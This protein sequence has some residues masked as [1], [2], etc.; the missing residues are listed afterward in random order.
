MLQAKAN[1]L[2][3]YPRQREPHDR[4]TARLGLR[5]SVEARHFTSGRLKIRC[6]ASIGNLYWQSTEKSVEE[7]RPRLP[8]LTPPPPP[9][10]LQDDFGDLSRRWPPADLFPPGKQLFKFYRG[11]KTLK[12]SYRNRLFCFQHLSFSNVS[13]LQF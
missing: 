12:V 10:S 5:F 11:V 7:D 8:P 4:E 3:R 1:Q 6:S 2:L 13:K 9:T